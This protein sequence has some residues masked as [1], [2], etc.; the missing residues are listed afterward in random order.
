[1][2]NKPVQLADG[3]I[4]CPS[5]SEHR[6]W[7]V[8]FERTSDL[9]K[10]WEVIGPINDGKEF[11]AIQPSV[12]TYN[13]GRMQVL[14]RSQQNV[15]TQSWSNDGG[16]TWSKMSATSLPNPSAGTDAVTL[17]D[18]RQLLVYNHS[19]GGRGEPGR[20]LLNVALSE[21]GRSWK[22][23]LTLENQRGEYSY[24]AVIQAADGQIHITYTYQRKSVKYVVL[25]PEKLR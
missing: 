5:S 17:Q 13:G 18:G 21:D 22:P 11:G 19:R 9:G 14:C 16:A 7:R 4:L 2:K 3:S 15:I 6:G 12:L 1:V 24:P 10:T 8:H 23:V 20:K 25:D